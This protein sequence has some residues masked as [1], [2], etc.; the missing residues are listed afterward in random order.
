MRKG[1]KLIALMLAGMMAVSTLAGC[2][3][4]ENKEKG[5][6][7]KNI[8]IKIW[9]AGLGTKWLD[10]LI[11]GFEKKH[12]EYHVTY[13]AT[14]DA[15]AIYATYGMA[16]MDPTDLYFSMKS[17]ETTNVPLND[18]LDSKADG[19]SKTIREKFDPNYLDT[20]I[21]ADGNVYSLTYGGGVYGI[22]Y[23]ANLFEEAGIKQTPRTTNELAIVCDTLFRKGITPWC[24]FKNNG[25]WPALTEVFTM[26]YDGYDYYANNLYG[27]KDENGESPSL[28]VLTKK[29]GRYQTMKA[30]ETFLTSDYVLSG[31][32]SATHTVIQTQFLNRSA[33]MMVNGSW[34]ENEMSSVDIKDTFLTMKTPVLSSITD[35]L[36]TVKKDSELCALIDAI[37][38]VTDGK[39][40]IDDYRQGEDYVVGGKTV[41]AADWD[42]VDIARNTIGQ[43]Y[44]GNGAFIPAYSDAID[45]ATEFLRY[46]FSDE[47]LEIC[48]NVSKIAMPM[49]TDSVE[50]DRSSWSDFA[51]SNAE[52]LA[53]A[54]K[55]ACGEYYASKHPIYNAG[56]INSM[57]NQ[58]YIQYFCTNNEGDRQTAD[59]IW[60]G[61]MTYIEN[62]YES[63]W[64]A[65]MK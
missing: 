11:E 25:Y 35:K 8:E 31:S 64:L 7:A 50:I 45:G 33:A 14:A 27:C 39:A 41:S 53:A 56:A 44:S 61:I 15:S 24:H 19:E 65:N 3:K 54:K 42:Y 12:S 21:N 1:K 62:N 16:D 58:P 30:Y 28:N 10:A 26:Q 4:E 22:V 6:P 5:D 55:H 57:G 32:N 37:D 49:T 36:T 38:A 2:G 63:N 60:N 29:D 23:N 47:G 46:L 20:E 34:M 9:N 17:S 52:L 51:K 18:L 40:S 59:Q 43:N 48:A 13:T